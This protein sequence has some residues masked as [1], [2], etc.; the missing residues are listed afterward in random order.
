[1]GSNKPNRICVICQKQYHYCPS[2]NSEDTNKPTWY[3]TF[4]S[5]NCKNI[6]DVCTNW[7]DGNITEDEASEKIKKLDLSKIDNFF[8]S[9]QAQI[10]E[11]TAS[12]KKTEVSPKIEKKVTNNTDS[13]IKK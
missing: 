2:C 4:C 10:K 11:L 5:E 1:M 9:T 13:K 8:E 12:P 3:F 6:Y 7:R